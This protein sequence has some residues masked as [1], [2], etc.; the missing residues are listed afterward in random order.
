VST[1]SAE[2]ARKPLWKRLL[3]PVLWVAVL[4][5]VFGYFLPQIISYEDIWQ[6]IKGLSW[7]QLAIL[8]ACP[9]RATR[10]RMPAAVRFAGSFACPAS[11]LNPECG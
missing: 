9:R 3:K 4:A 6:A 11:S 10:A 7:W 5:F 8:L 2:P 1:A